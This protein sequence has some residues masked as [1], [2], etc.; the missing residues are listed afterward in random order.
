MAVPGDARPEDALPDDREAVDAAFAEIIAGYHLTADR[1]DPML[2]DPTADPPA[3]P[4][5]VAPAVIEVQ[6]FRFEPTATPPKA[7]PV[8][9][10][11]RFVPPPVEPLPRPGLPALLGWIGISYAVAFIMIT[12]VGIRLPDW[13]GWLA[14]VGFVGA[15]AIMISRLPKERPPNDGAVL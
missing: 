1:P 10:E 2:L 14:I 7:K 9:P 6:V 15:F 8:E 3:T 11:E 13:A 4:R 5:E 12:A